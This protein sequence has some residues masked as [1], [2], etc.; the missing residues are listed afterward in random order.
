MASN[1]IGSRTLAYLLIPRYFE[2]RRLPVNNPCVLWTQFCKVSHAISVQFRCNEIASIG[3]RILGWSR[4]WDVELKIGGSTADTV[5]VRGKPVSI[6]DPT[7][8]T[9]MVGA[10]VVLRF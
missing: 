9:N 10:N 2:N 7:N 4:P 1:I 5:T 3:Q 6:V 8:N